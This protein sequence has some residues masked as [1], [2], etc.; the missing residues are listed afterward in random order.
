MP[1]LSGEELQ[2]ELTARG[3]HL[4]II[5][6]TGDDDPETRRKAEKMKA[7]GFFRKTRL[8][9]KESVLFKIFLLALFVGALM[10]A[11][12]HA[13]AEESEVNDGWQFAGSLY[14]WGFGVYGETQS[15]TQI[16]AD[17]DDL[18]DALEIGFMGAFEARKGK[19][20][21]LTDVIY[22]DLEDDKTA[23]VF[24]PLGPGFNV[25]TN[26]N[27]NLEGWVLQFAGGYNL[28]AKGKSRLDVVGGVRYLD[29]DMDLKLSLQ[30]IPARF[31]TLAVSEGVWDGFFGLKGNIGLSKRW[32]L[33]YHF[34]FGTGESLVTWQALAG[35]GFR[36]AKWLDIAL[37]YRH[38]EWNFRSDQVVDDLSFSGPLLGL[39][40]RF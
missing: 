8:E 19:W 12:V 10:L 20:L 7:V 34:D 38:L 24:V 39:I 35:V 5:V 6:V 13:R 17:F 22:F 14:M 11:P 36:A 28:V 29:L 16:K 23:N 1:G 9:M 26:I 25:A 32:Y 40:F 21:L 30:T 2:V 4:S 3:I 33:P 15:D 31:R 18:F 37:V 27:T